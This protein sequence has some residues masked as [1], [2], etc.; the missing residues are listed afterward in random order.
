MASEILRLR[1][2][3]ASRD[4]RRVILGATKAEWSEESK[5][6]FTGARLGGQ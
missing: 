6:V 5:S 3:I 4:F 1:H 2:L